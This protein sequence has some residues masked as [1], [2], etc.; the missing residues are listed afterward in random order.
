VHDAYGELS[1]LRERLASH[2][3]PVAMLIGA[4]ASCSVRD[5]AGPLVPAI[6]ELGERCERAVAELGD[7]F[8]SGYEQLQE[9]LSP[10]DG[11]R[12]PNVE[13]L[14][15][16]VRR[17]LAAMG[18]DDRLAGLD[19]DGL[20]DVERTVCSTIAEAALPDGE[21]ISAVLPH[22]AL[23]RWA[24]RVVRTRPLELFTTNYDTL[25]ERALED[26]L[27]P[28]FDGF[29]G[30]LRPFF[31]PSSLVHQHSAPARDWVRLWKLH[32]SVTWR[33][34]AQAAGDRRRIVRGQESADGALIYPSQ[35]K[36]DE[37]RKQ[38]YAA[39]LDRLDRVLTHQDGAIL[40]ATGFSF[41]DQ[42]INEVVFGALD[43]RPRT[44]VIALQF[45]DPQPG[46]ELADRARRHHNLLVYGPNEAIVGGRLAP[47]RRLDATATGPAPP[48]MPAADGEGPITHTDTGET[49]FEL[50][51]FAQLTLF[52]DSIAAGV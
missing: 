23:A 31:A 12:P 26:E 47:W 45:E 16:S 32:G 1:K 30:A 3:L 34:E 8:A 5:A 11:G 42:H 13:D 48:G 43:V 14:L 15:S 49:R 33:W 25:L 29:V 27:V 22:H 24:G 41:G 6:V 9:E 17:K 36:Y 21:R 2:D 20:E 50:G 19:R 37:S 38:P 4:G 10:E 7:A 52:L 18:P 40:I 46:D 28:Y 51:D 44:H 39:M 35:H